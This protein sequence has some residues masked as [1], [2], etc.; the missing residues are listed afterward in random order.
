[1]DELSLEN[2]ACHTIALLAAASART[3]PK[4]KGEDYLQ[5]HLVSEE[6]KQKIIARMREIAEDKGQNWDR[7]ALSLERSSYVLLIGVDGSKHLGLNCEACGFKT[8]KEMKEALLERKTGPSCV[9]RIY[10]LGIAIGSA[11]KTAQ[12][13]NADSRIMWRAG[14][15]AQQLDILP[16]C[17]AILSLPLAITGKSPY[18]DR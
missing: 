16:D 1:M 6:E 7:D 2:K 4:S 5:V 10:D 11:A 14:Y 18:F 15:A 8:C 13:H 9:F 3:A 17:T 12:I